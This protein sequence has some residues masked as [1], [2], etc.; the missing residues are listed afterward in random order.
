MGRSF[1]QPLSPVSLS[2]S[3]LPGWSR[4][5]MPM[6]DDVHGN[7]REFTDLEEESERENELEEDDDAMTDAL[8]DEMAQQIL[9]TVREGGHFWAL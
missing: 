3:V 2:D 6:S 7:R 8:A 4:E 5:S 9:D 1:S